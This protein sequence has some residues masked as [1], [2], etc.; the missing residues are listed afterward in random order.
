MTFPAFEQ[1]RAKFFCELR[2]DSDRR[3]KGPEEIENQRFV[4]GGKLNV[5]LDDLA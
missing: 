2:P 3:L 5:F 1:L 4:C